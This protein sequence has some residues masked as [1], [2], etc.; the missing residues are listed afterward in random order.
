M[1]GEYTR[2]SDKVEGKKPAL[3]A[4]EFVSFRVYTK[5]KE[6]DTNKKQNPRTDHMVK[7]TI[8]AV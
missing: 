6:P 3:D 5:G 2:N 4:S 7:M 8:E 1:T